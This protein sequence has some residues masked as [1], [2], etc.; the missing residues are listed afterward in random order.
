M[1][2]ALFPIILPVI[3]LYLIRWQINVLAVGDEEAIALGININR[4]RIIVVL[5]A[6]LMT[7]A[8][9]SISGIIGWVGLLVPHMARMLAGPN[10]HRLLPTSLLLGSGYLLLVDNIGRNALAVE[11]P[12]G[13]LTALI[14]A[15]FF[16]FLLSKV[17]RGW[18]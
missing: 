17:R 5:C 8:A 6:T 10:F 3:V 1:L 15:P 16:I 7:A 12:L 4:I 2:F 9:V 13:I 14:G 11:I 18:A